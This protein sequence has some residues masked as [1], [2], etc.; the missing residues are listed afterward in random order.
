MGT[1]PT[2]PRTPRTPAAPPPRRAAQQWLPL[3]FG[4]LAI[5]LVVVGVILVLSSWQ[6]TG[7]LPWSPTETPTPTATPTPTPVPPTPTP[8]WTP[9]PS[10][11]PTQTP[12]PTPSEPFPYTV[13]EGDTLFTIAEKFN[14]DVVTLMLMNGLSNDSILFVGQKLTIPLPNMEPPTPTPL[15][16]NLRPGDVILYFVM[17]ND[18]L[19]TI[20][21]RFLTTEEAI[22]EANGL[23]ENAVLYVGDLIKVPVY[24]AATPTPTP[25]P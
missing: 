11:T 3:F 18:T 5:V 8:T 20:A 14:V 7:R 1:V 15:P 25:K 4:G 21:Q 19:T 24:L 2:Q 6:Q 23:D 12:T 13:Q 10:P 17:P 22:R 9:T 16:T